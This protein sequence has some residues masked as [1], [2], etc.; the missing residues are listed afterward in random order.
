MA[1]RSDGAAAGPVPASVG[2]VEAVR[3][4]A[5]RA[6]ITA[7]DADGMQVGDSIAAI[8]RALGRLSNPQ[9]EFRDADAIPGASVRLVYGKQVRTLAEPLHRSGMPD[10]FTAASP[11]A[12]SPDFR[13]LELPDGYFCHYRDGPLVVAPAGDIV[14]RDFSSR[15]AGL[16]HFYATPLRQVLADAMQVDG[17]VIVLADDVRPLNFCHWIVDWLPRLACLGEQARRPDTFVAVPPLGADYQWATLRLCGF[18]PERVIQLDAMQGLRARRLLVPSDLTLIPHP[19]HKAAPWLTNYLRG[20]LGYGAFL[21][22]MD[23]P[24]RRRKLYVSRGDAA[25]RRVL[26]EAELIASLEPLG[27]ETVSLAGM[28][29]VRQIAT[30]GCASHIVAPHG[31]GLANIVFADPATTL[32][33]I[34][35]AT[36]G[37]AAYYVLAAGLGMTYASYISH[38]ITPGSRAQLDDMTVDI[39]DFLARCRDLL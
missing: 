27:Y 3:L 2:K 28:P 1:D 9:V 22:G 32:V 14:A 21:A 39:P 11:T 38:G 35:P 4:L 36:Y 6:G 13:V 24:P 12:H 5:A 29:P 17:T 7:F 34:F 18:P 33:E 26:N 8:G 30:F 10:C 16:V 37:T 23:G 25:G 15:F 20:A 31:A 19:G